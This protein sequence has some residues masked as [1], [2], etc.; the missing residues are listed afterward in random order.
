MNSFLRNGFGS[1]SLDP[2]LSRRGKVRIANGSEVAEGGVGGFLAIGRVDH[3]GTRRLSLLENRCG[4]LWPAP[5]PRVDFFHFSPWIFATELEW[6]SYNHGIVI[7]P[8][9]KYIR[10][11]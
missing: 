4:A 9:G 1:K 2:L 6:V 10:A 5:R 3:A 7:S 11:I 8:S